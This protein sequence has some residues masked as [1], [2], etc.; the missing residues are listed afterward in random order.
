MIDISSYF[1]SLALLAGLVTI[2]TGYLNTHML[3]TAS[4]TIKQIVSW[5]VSV[6]LVYV[7][8]LKGIGIA[9][10]ATILDVALN[11]LAVGLIANGVFDVTLVQSIL[12]FIKANP[13][14]V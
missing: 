13:K 2:L 7:G 3:K 5:V 4:S 11:G 8:Y 9:E 12:T 6:A 1:G 14:K 10:T